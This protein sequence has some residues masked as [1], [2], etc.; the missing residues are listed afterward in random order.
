M[1]TGP[2]PMDLPPYATLAREHRLIERALEVLRR[3]CDDAVRRKR[4]DP[5]IAREILHFLREFADRNHHI[6][7]ERI[8]FPAI[9]SASFFPGC[10]LV[11]EHELA[12]TRVRNM[13][14]AVERSAAG[15]EAARRVFVQQ[16]R[17]YIALLRSHIA[18]EDDCL[19]NVTARS[20]PSGDERERLSREFDERE[21]AEMGEQAFARFTALIETLEARVGISPVA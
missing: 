21:A 19:A 7:E 9:E 15:D 20:F 4:L 11:S 13:A 1:E 17:S 10:G 18:K 5:E 14:A 6:K 16:A 3:F 2:F 12:R 8:L